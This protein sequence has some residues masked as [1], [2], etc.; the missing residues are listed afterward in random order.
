MRGKSK[1]NPHLATG[2]ELA[3]PSAEPRVTPALPWVLGTEVRDPGGGKE[4]TLT[5]H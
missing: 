2:A 4:V 1:K 3:L 5:L